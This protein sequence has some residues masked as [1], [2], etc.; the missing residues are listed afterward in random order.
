VVCA[1]IIITHGSSEPELWA[2]TIVTYHGCFCRG[3]PVT[4]DEP[5]RWS[6]SQRKHRRRRGRDVYVPP[7]P[8]T[9]S[10]GQG[11]R[12]IVKKAIVVKGYTDVRVHTTEYSLIH[13]L[14]S[15]SVLKEL[16]RC[17][18]PWGSVIL[19][20]QRESPSWIGSNLVSGL[21]MPSL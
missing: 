17:C 20:Y 15:A 16:M 19:T 13:D 14:A 2:V 9:G 10:I 3:V 12:A 7:S 6:I 18:T 21:S 1:P 11:T 5:W 4:H 8:T